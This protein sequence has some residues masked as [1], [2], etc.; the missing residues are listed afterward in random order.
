MAGWSKGRGR[1]VFPVRQTAQLEP[2]YQAEELLGIKL[3]RKPGVREN[4]VMYSQGDRKPLEDFASKGGMMC[5][6]GCLRCKECRKASEE[7]GRPV[8]EALQRSRWQMKVAWAWVMV[9]V[10]RS[11]VGDTFWVRASNLILW[12]CAGTLWWLCYL[13]WLTSA[14]SHGCDS[15]QELPLT[16][17]YFSRTE[18]ALLACEQPTQSA[19]WAIITPEQPQL[20]GDWSH[21]NAPV[22]CLSSGRL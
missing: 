5:F 2:N 3:Q 15:S 7:A 9:E 16:C 18:G 10:G 8:W 1:T 21:I 12:L 17:G 22:T 6:Q 20:T 11:Q 13:P 14:F 19:A 4:L